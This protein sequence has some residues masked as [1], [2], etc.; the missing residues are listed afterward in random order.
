MKYDGKV[1]SCKLKPGISI[2]KILSAI[3]VG[4]NHAAKCSQP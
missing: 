4:Q 2:G 1:T 3:K